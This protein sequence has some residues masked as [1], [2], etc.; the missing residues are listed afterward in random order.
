M[1]MI[2]HCGLV[3]FFWEFK[4]LE[5]Y[6]K[7]DIGK[8]RD[9]N[10]DNFYYERLNSDLCFALVCDGMGGVSGGNVASEVAV[11]VLRDSLSKNLKMDLNSFQVNELVK[12]SFDAA[13]L[14]ILKHASFNKSLAGMGTTVVGLVLLENLAYFFNVGDSRAYLF[15]ESGL[16]Q[17]TVDHSYV[18]TLIDDGK[19]TVDEARIH[20]R[21]NEITR[22]LG[23]SKKVEFDFKLVEVKK[24]DFLLLCSDGLTNFCFETEIEEVLRSRKSVKTAVC[25]LIDC[26]NS[27][28]GNDNITAILLKI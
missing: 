28:G 5:I 12:F 25:N 8:L 16:K 27:N 20:P 18:Q 14:E 10:Q 2:S 7:S 6:G 22:A 24:N 9:N 17:L 4:L 11:N 21:K 19:I 26:A 1:I 3:K 13:N 23:I 15:D